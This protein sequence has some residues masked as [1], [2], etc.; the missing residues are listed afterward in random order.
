MATD[1]QEELKLAE[2]FNALGV[3]HHMLNKPE[4]AVEYFNKSIL[5]YERNQ[6]EIG[7]GNSYAEMGNSMRR[8]DINRAKSYMEKGISILERNN[9]NTLESAYDNYGVILHE[10]N[11]PDSALIYYNR[12]LDLKTQRRTVLEFLI[13]CR[14]LLLGKYF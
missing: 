11:K 4:L 3:V 1:L 14:K 9:A 10:L 5:L 12:S 7:A 6:N 13:V 8:R 2:L